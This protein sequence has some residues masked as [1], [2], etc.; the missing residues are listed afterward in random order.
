MV[1]TEEDALVGFAEV[2]RRN[3]RVR[4]LGG[5]LLGLLEAST[6]RA[7]VEAL[8]RLARWMAEFDPRFP[9]PL[10]TAPPVPAAAWRRLAALV[11][12]LHDPPLRDP[13]RIQLGRLLAESDG[14]ALLAQS[15]LPN[16]RGLLSET[17]DRLFR[18]ILPEPPDD[19]NLAVVVGRMF[20]TPQALRFLEQLPPELFARLCRA[21]GADDARG[22]VFASLAAA[23]RDAFV[24]VSAR[25][26]GLGLSEP[27][28]ERSRRLPLQ[29]SPFLALARTGT[30]VAAA[31]RDGERRWRAAVQGCREELRAVQAKL[32][33]TGISVDVVFEME[34]MEQALRRLERLVAVMTA[35]SGAAEAAAARDLLAVVVRARQSDR[36]LRA[37]AYS[38]LHLLA[39][40]LV[41]RAGRTGEHYIALTRLQYWHLLGTAAGGGLVTLATA[42][43]KVRIAALHLAPFL[44]GLLAGTNYALSFILI[45]LCGFTLATKQ[46]SMTAATLAESIREG[47]GPERM[48]DLVTHVTRIVRSQLCAAFGNI[49]T[50]A[51]AAIAFDLVYRWRSGHS[52]LSPEKAD[53][54]LRSLHPLESGT[55]WY[56]AITGVILWASS[57]AGGWI[58]NFCVYRRLP[59]AIAEHRLGDVVGR[60]FLQRMSARFARNISGLGSGVALGLMLG[61]TPVLGAFFGLPLDVRHVTLSAGTLA[62][63]LA[64]LDFVPPRT[65]L[66]AVVGIGVI[67]VL[68]LAVSFLC[69]LT[70]ALRAK[71]VPRRDRWALF[72]AI[73]G[74]LL[75]RPLDFILPPGRS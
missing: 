27:I 20:P 13:V 30:L 64:S 10:A 59:Q 55:I 6:L 40:K 52:F 24:L 18:R 56:A 22:V 58:E 75:R 3:R 7:R 73:V 32:E 11:T 1:V 2:D 57:L 12:V 74:R 69:A 42:S 4:E 14:V 33:E 38:N 37:L 8:V 35:P 15:G 39:R 29:Q 70:V 51:L 19:Q 50:V 17:A 28:R 65:A 66:P 43:L 31:D 71:E 23:V 26:Q 68:N 34:I 5:L 49:G 62:V 44:E 41:E 63:A 46:P 25:V 45:Q 53:A 54:V 21:L 36:S 60:P 72:G 16:D 48:G 9:M 67:F 47:A 61:M